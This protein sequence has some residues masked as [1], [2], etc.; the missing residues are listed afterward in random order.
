MPSQTNNHNADS[1]YCYNQSFHN[2]L[3]FRR[4]R[5][6]G[7]LVPSDN[8][9]SATKRAQG[10]L[11]CFGQ[12]T[13]QMPAEQRALNKHTKNLLNNLLLTCRLFFASLATASAGF[14]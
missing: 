1:N 6:A 7:S 3:L 9:K 11:D 8:A 5:A 12:L 13:G 10:F 14:I 2:N 4:P